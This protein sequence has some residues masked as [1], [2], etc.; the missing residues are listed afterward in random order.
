MTI[1]GLAEAV[2]AMWACL[3]GAQANEAL[4]DLLPVVSE[5]ARPWK[6]PFTR[7]GIGTQPRLS[8]CLAASNCILRRT[9]AEKS[10]EPSKVS[11][12]APRLRTI[13]DVTKA[14][15]R[16]VAAMWTGRI[17]SQDGARIA[18]ALALLRQCFEAAQ[19]EMIERRLDAL[20]GR[21]E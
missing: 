8:A 5:S 6:P 19:L 14:T 17:A 10:M 9:E 18:N 11:D 2:L 12:R 20:E 13:T 16:T 1:D 21:K 3:A 4:R 7:R 15:A